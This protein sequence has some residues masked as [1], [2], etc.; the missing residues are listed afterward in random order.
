MMEKN[1]MIGAQ[2]PGCR[3][4]PGGKC[5]DLKKEASLLD[6]PA[7]EIDRLDSDTI[8]S[9]SAAVRKV[10]SQVVSPETQE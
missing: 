9:A 3:C 8:K 5:G 1:G 7:E 2:T 4:N 10:F 6:V